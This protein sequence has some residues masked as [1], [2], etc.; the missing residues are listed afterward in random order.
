MEGKQRVRKLADNDGDETQ[1]RLHWPGQGEEEIGCKR[2]NA[3]FSGRGE[4]SNSL[5]LGR[6]VARN[7]PNPLSFPR[8]GECG[9]E[10]IWKSARAGEQSLGRESCASTEI[11]AG[12]VR[13]S[14]SAY[15]WSFPWEEAKWETNTLSFLQRKADHVKCLSSK[16]MREKTGATEVMKKASKIWDGGAKGMRAFFVCLLSCYTSDIDSLQRS[17]NIKIIDSNAMSILVQFSSNP[18]SLLTYHTHLYFVFIALN[19]TVH[20]LWKPPFHLKIYTEHLSEYV[21]SHFSCIWVFATLWTVAWQASLSMGFSRQEYWSGL[22]YLPPGDCS[23][24]GI[25]PASVMSPS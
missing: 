23:D 12:G 18:S 20:T 4:I 9:E 16:A 3:I 15:T 22:P 2:K 24:P 19:C 1:P 25:E 7:L 5:C 14:E 10:G 17:E 6:R 21:L 8:L 11:L 13:E